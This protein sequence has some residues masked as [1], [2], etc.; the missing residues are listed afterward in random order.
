MGFSSSAK[1]VS[2][3]RKLAS[4][5]NV[6]LEAFEEREYLSPLLLASIAIHYLL[7]DGTSKAQNR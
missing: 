1:I 6:S 5:G 2:G 4:W 7:T 3:K